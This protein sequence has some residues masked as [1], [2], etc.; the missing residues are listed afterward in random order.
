[1]L[2]YVLNVI[3][4]GN[5]RFDAILVKENYKANFCLEGV[6]ASCL[7]CKSVTLKPA[8]AG[9]LML[10]SVNGKPT[11]QLKMGCGTSGC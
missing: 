9:E 2:S 1:M 6:E 7:S 5:C 11:A 3:N 8:T 4:V 10:Y